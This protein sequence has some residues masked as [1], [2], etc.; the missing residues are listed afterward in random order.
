MLAGLNDIVFEVNRLMIWQ[1][2][3]YM[4]K[5]VPI[6]NQTKTKHELMWLNPQV[7]ANYDKSDLATEQT[8][9][10]FPATYL[11]EKCNFRYLRAERYSSEANTFFS[12]NLYLNYYQTWGI[13]SERTILCFMVGRK[14]KCV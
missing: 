2:R 14:R 10:Q 5:I 3:Y 11:A 4:C 1:M 9:L 8:F 12:S 7:S 6:W 13:T